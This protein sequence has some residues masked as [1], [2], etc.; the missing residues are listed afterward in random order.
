M[1]KHVRMIVQQLGDLGIAARINEKRSNGHVIMTI[2]RGARWR[3]MAVAGS[4]KVPEYTVKAAVRE[5][6]KLLE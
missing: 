1:K 4:P 6:V 3:T 5:A 2:S